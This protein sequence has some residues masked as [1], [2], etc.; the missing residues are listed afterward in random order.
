MAKVPNAVEILPKI[1]TAWV[2]CTS[3][4][5]RQ[6]DRQTDD[7]RTDGRQHIANVNVS[8]RSLKIVGFC[9]ATVGHLSSCWALVS[10]HNSHKWNW[11]T[12][13]RR[14]FQQCLLSAIR[15][16]AVQPVLQYCDDTVV[17]VADVCKLYFHP[18]SVY[19]SL[20]FVDVGDAGWWLRICSASRGESIA[21]CSFITSVDYNCQSG[22]N[23]IHIAL[24]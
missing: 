5:D 9:Y 14:Q 11:T 22:R 23:Y 12:W 3:V 16:S 13:C 20:Y 2:G 7:R 8:S 18:I 24:I 17:S 10:S 1:T 4:T 15:C 21:A 19:T 6:T